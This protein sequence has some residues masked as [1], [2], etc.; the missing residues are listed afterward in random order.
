MKNPLN[1]AIHRLAARIQFVKSAMGSAHAHAFPSILAILMLAANQN[2]SLTVTVPEKKLAFETNV[3][4][5]VQEFAV[6]M[7]SAES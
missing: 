1:P 7:P 2:V 4:I 6:Q 5:H 3:L